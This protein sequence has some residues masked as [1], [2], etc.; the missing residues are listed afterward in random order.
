MPSPSSVSL[1]IPV[2][3]EGPNLDA[4]FNRPAPV[5]DAIG[6]DRDVECVL[7][8]DGSRDDSLAK[9]LAARARDP[10][11]KIVEFNRNYGQHAAVF[12]GFEHSSGDVVVTLDADLQNPPEEIPKLLAQI[13]AGHD[14]VGTRRLDRQDSGFRKLASS[15]VNRITKKMI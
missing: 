11:V 8:D 4:L 3:N 12:A 2:F 10:R 6:R 7:V 14:V 1:V 13:D 15:I 9:L 5:M